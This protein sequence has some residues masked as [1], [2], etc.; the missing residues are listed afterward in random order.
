MLK[1]ILAASAVAVM[2]SSAA[3]AD[4]YVIDPAHT[5]ATFEATHMGTSTNRGRFDK[6]EGMV[7]FDRKAKTGKV[8]ITIDTGSINTGT[9]GFD[10]HLKSADFFN[11]EA[12]PTARFVGDD[13]VFQGDKLVAIKGDLTMLG[14][15][16]PVTLEVDSFNCYNHPML[17]R[18]VCGGDFH[19]TISR[20]QW[21]MTWGL[22][23][24]MSPQVKLVIQAEAIK[25]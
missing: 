21:G 10:K 24:G 6:K 4:T 5:F 3:Y 23:M 8:D 14:K 2:A 16:N 22:S 19:A 18:E 17:K 1:K 15:V 12:F 9:P 7:E 20:D 13:L 11:S 25:Q